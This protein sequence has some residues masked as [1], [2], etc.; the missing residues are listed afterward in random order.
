[1]LA[2]CAAAVEQ[3]RLKAPAAARAALT[4]SRFASCRHSPAATD[5]CNTVP[6]PPC[7]LMCCT[8]GVLSVVVKLK[9]VGQLPAQP[10]RCR[11]DHAELASCR[12]C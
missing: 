2:E 3:T 11:R 9:P 8:P 12:I 7:A 5:Q 10:L 6:Q 4:A 1:M